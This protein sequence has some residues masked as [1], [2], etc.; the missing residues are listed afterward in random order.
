MPDQLI[1]YTHP[2]H[3]A[4]SSGG[5]SRDWAAYRTE[6]LDYDT[7]MKGAAYLA[8][9]PMRKV[10]AVRHGDVVITEAAAICA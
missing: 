7:T 10:P 1:F 4:E 9:N 5:C 6:L 8:I 3:A 2:C